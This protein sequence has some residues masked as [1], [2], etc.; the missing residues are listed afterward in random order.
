MI[1]T[2]KPTILVIRP[3]IQKFSVLPL[4]LATS[5]ST[6]PTMAR[7]RPIRPQH[8]MLTIPHTIEAIAIPW[9]GGVGLYP[10]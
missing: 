10:L 3:A 5:E 2:Q 7:T 9:A 8:T 4:F 1:D 6:K